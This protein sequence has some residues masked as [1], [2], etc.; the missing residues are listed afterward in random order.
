MW[1]WEMAVLF[2]DTT[3]STG[4]K[5]KCHLLGWFLI[6]PEEPLVEFNLLP[7]TSGRKGVLAPNL[8]PPS[9]FFFSHTRLWTDFVPP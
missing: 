9:P 6:K 3:P 2:N 8:T 1:G 5:Q 4:S 7:F